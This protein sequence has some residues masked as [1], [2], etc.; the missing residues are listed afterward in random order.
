MIRAIVATGTIGGG[1]IGF[2]GGSLVNA[3]TD[4]G[5]WHAACAFAT[6]FCGFLTARE[7]VHAREGWQPKRPPMGRLLPWF[8]FAGFFVYPA[9]SIDPASTTANKQLDVVAALTSTSV[10]AVVGFAVVRWLKS[11][12]SSAERES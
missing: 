2:L 5:L 8:I 6:A 1:I 3:L 9:G 11:V 10:Y 4:G 12:R 7:Y